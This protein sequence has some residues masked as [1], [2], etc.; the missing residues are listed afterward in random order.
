MTHG[1][2]KTLAFESD[3]PLLAELTVYVNWLR[4]YGP[5]VLEAQ[6]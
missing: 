1:K 6:A 5:F 4:C 2:Y 3:L